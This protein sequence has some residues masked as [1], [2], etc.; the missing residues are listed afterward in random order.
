MG[1]IACRE[2]GIMHAGNHVRTNELL[3]VRTYN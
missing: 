1:I 3:T 2:L